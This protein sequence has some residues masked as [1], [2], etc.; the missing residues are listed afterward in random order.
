MYIAVNVVFRCVRG[1]SS[2][3]YTDA[4]VAVLKGLGNRNAI[5]RREGRKKV[6]RGKRRKRGGGGN[7]GKKVGEDSDND[8]DDDDGD[9][10]EKYQE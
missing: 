2:W 8:N 1:G 4:C 10:D 3:S 5:P 9:E 6:K 7:E